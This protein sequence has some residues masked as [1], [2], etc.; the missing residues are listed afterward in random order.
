ML[1]RNKYAVPRARLVYTGRK[2]VAELKAA[3]L[4]SA[5]ADNNNDNNKEEK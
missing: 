3:Q 4:V 2:T 5:K 1:M